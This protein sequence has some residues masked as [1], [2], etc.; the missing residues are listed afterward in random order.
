MLIRLYVC[1][2]IIKKIREMK[3]VSLALGSLLI[4]SLVF[5]DVPAENTTVFKVDAE[6]SKVYW[7]GKK[8]GGE[9]TGTINLRNSTV[10]VD[11]TNVLSATINMDMNSIVCT[12]VTNEGMN[13]RLVDHLKSD[14]F[15]SVDKHAQSVFEATGFKSTGAGNY[16][17]VGKMTIKGITH[18][19]SFPVKVDIKNGQLTANGTATL[20][21]TKWEIRFRSGRFFPDLGNNLIHDEFEIKF[22][23][24]AS[25]SADSV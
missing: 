21:R 9:H 14:D 13:K 12:D 11:G 23:L 19:I 2:E 17:V 8:I 18:E 16:D 25:A 15:F 6:K 5:A 7:T 10:N 20:D 24:V 1:C 22:D 3:K 4:A